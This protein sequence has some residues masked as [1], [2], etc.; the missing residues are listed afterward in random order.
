MRHH[1]GVMSSPAHIGILMLDTRF[2][3]PPGDA[4]NPDSWPVNVSIRRVDQASPERI[5][6]RNHASLLP[7]FIAAG[8]LLQADGAR[9]ITTTCGFLVLHQQTLQDALDIP[10]VTSSLLAVAEI[11]RALPNGQRCGVLTIAN[12]SLTEAHHRAAKLPADTPI[13]TTETGT[14][15]TKA[16]LENSPDLDISAARADNLAAATAL[17][18]AYPDLGAIVLECTNMPPYAVEISKAT[19]LPVY[20]LTDL[21]MA[22]LENRPIRPSHVS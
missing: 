19:D 21:V 14:H 7:D 12:S 3:R 2:P 5:V 1:S 4:G 17:K 11:D 13:G 16:I 20:S 22:R 9:I 10:V 8:K 6:R 15:F 18:Q